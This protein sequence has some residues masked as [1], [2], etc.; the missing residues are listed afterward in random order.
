[1]VRSPAHLQ[2]LDS[3]EHNFGAEEQILPIPTLAPA[4]FTNPTHSRVRRPRNPGQNG[5][6]HT[7]VTMWRSTQP[8][9]GRAWNQG[10]DG[11]L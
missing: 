5:P 11:E 10:F 9:F 4:A 7:R 8:D 3:S 2:K 6:S 1:M